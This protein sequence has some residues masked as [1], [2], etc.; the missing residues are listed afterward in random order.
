MFI[1]IRR[2]PQ[3]RQNTMEMEDI[4]G[5]LTEEMAMSLR[6]QLDEAIIR[7]LDNHGYTFEDKGEAIRFIE[8]NCES[9]IRGTE[10]YYLVHDIPF[11]MYD[12]EIEIKHDNGKVY[13]TIGGYR[14]I[15]QE[16]EPSYEDVQTRF[17]PR[18]H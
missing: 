12:S 6:M 9:M 13:S 17:C 15:Y 7:G 16:R 18:S 10:R 5:N 1:E 4:L 14:F 2:N 3:E 8:K 11:L